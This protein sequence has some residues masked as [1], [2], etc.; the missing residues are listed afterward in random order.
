MTLC[1][2]LSVES[3][4]WRIAS[5]HYVVGSEMKPKDAFRLLTE[6]PGFC[7]ICGAQLAKTWRAVKWDAEKNAFDWFASDHTAEQLA[8]LERFR[9]L[10]PDKFG[11]RQGYLLAAVIM[12][13]SMTAI[14]V[15]E[16]A[17][18]LL[19][20]EKEKREWALAGKVKQESERAKRARAALASSADG[21]RF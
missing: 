10:P 18:A 6:R 3:R 1:D 14:D 15:W 8:D 12:C 9:S 4:A 16:K 7:K 5:L 11:L 20:L 2:A 19:L 17:R 13:E 21:D